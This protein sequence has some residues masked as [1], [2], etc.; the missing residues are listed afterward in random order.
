M[1]KYFVEFTGILILIFASLLT[2]RD[3][4]IMAIVTFSV[5]TF[6]KK[7]GAYFS[8]LSSSAA[9]L[10][11]RESSKDAFYMAIAN[12]LAVGAVV[13]TFLPTENLLNKI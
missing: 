10:I 3:P 7:Y 1:F 6:G 12:W 9:Y 2:D 13:I 8:T 5:F 4:L 11:G